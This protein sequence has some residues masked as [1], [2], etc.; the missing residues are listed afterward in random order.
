SRDVGSPEIL[1]MLYVLTAA[2]V[3]AV[4]PG[5]WTN[6]KAELL[7]E[8]YERAML[9]LSGEPSQFHETERIVRIRQ[10]VFK[11]LTSPGTAGGRGGPLGGTDPDRPR[12]P[13]PFLPADDS[14]RADCRRL[15]MR[16]ALGTEPGAHPKHVSSA[17]ECGGASGDYARLHR[18]RMLQQDYGSADRQ[19]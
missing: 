19:T 1:R 17:D 15:E 10:E 3:T 11:R 7:A 13:A 18:I 5:A 2:D 6:W 4:G 12:H 8:L 14:S 9:V 16:R